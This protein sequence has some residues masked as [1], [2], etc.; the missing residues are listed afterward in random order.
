MSKYLR[1]AAAT[2][3]SPPQSK[4][5]NERQVQNSAG[6][7]AFAVDDWKRLDRFLILGSEGGSYYASEQKLTTENIEAVKRCVAS[8]GVRVVARI[9]EISDAGR[10]PKNDPALL[11]LA[12]A[13]AKG[14]D[15]TRS[16]ALNA[17]PQVARISTHLFH[18]IAFV[19]QFRGWGRGLRRAVENWYAT[20]SPEQ[21][22]DQVTKYQQRDGWSHRDLMRLRHIVFTGSYQAVAKWVVKGE[23]SE[24][25]PKRIE[26]HVKLQSSKSP[27]E[28]ATLIRE[29][30]LARESVPTELLNEAEVWAAL[31]EKMPLT[32]MIRNLGN[33]GKCGLLK[34]MSEAAMTV[35]TRLAEQESI[36][37]ARVHPIQLLIAAKTYE[38]GHG[39]RGSG[40][41]AVA[42]KVVDALDGAFYLAF[43]NIEPTGKRFYLGMDISGSMYGGTV[44][45]IPGLT[46]AV[47]SGAMAMVTVKSEENYYSAGFTDRMEKISLSPKQRLDD[48]VKVMRKMSER[49]GRTDCAQPMRDALAQ[50]IEVD[51]FVIYTDNETWAG[52]MHPTVALQL[53]RNKM[54]ISSKLIICGMVSDGFTIADPTDAGML[55]VVGFDS[56]TPQI[57]SEFAKD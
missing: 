23:L 12:W 20:K 18:Y 53:Y 29:Y 26:G 17:L 46:P 45:G 14:D 8:D 39:L 9:V 35:A 15:A 49:M 55:D 21:F 28:A 7:F 54:G 52:D 24:G 34:P 47:A 32:A 22:A 25:L 42:P 50:K 2:A 41:W 19:R 40:S 51:A 13:S 3:I 6:G 33:M 1:T 56:A 11:A 36:R 48:V 30:G 10:A 44:A 27:K 57:I 16:K 4:P 37:K 5:L 31:L 43:Q 38:S